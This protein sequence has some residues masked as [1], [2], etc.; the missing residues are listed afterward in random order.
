MQKPKL[1]PRPQ[2]AGWRP[3][4]EK[5]GGILGKFTRWVEEV[6]LRSSGQP[7]E[8]Q[9]AR[10][11]VCPIDSRESLK[12]FHQGSDT[13]KTVFRSNSGRVDW[14]WREGKIGA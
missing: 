8:G 4:F 3:L 7:V 9:A 10:F 14:T 13:I 1:E 2:V 6:E 5:H 11:G 12:V